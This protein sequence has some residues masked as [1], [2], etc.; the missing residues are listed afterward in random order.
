MRAGE[1]VFATIKSIFGDRVYPDFLPEGMQQRPAASFQYI[2]SNAVNT[3]DAGFTGLQ[4]VRIQIDV[5]DHKFEDAMSA[6][7]LVVA[8]LTAPGLSLT[9]TYLGQRNLT[10]SETRQARISMDFSI[11]EQL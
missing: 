7:A 4:A 3:M 1:L 9:V 6:A 2:S 10:E 5:L 8:A 11:W